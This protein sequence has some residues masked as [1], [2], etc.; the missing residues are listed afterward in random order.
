MRR[1]LLSE[2]GLL[3][4]S[5]HFAMDFDYWVRLALA[6]VQAQHIDRTL[7]G[8]RHHTEAKTN[9]LY[10]TRIADRYR[11]LEKTFSSSV[12]PDHYLC[13][14]REAQAS[15]DLTAAYIAYQARDAIL[16]RKYAFQ[17]IRNARLALSW[18]GVAILMVSLTGARG[19]SEIGYCLRA[20]RD[21]W[22]RSWLFSR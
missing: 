4:E 5:L 9:R 17:H 1:S 13:R 8:F 21:L 10:R 15:A 11:I 18:L 14:R 3:D 16:A 6:G 20:I 12:L 2:V 7:A 19:I 22:R